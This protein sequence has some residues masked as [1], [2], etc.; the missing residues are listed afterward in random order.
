MFSSP[1]QRFGNHRLLVSN[2]G[3]ALVVSLI[4]II[5]IAIVLVGY[6]TTAGIERQTVQSHYAKIQAD[7]LNSMAVGVVASRLSTIPTTG[8]SWWIS[9]PG[10]I[11]SAPYTGT[12]TRFVELTSG[13]STAVIVDQS[14]DLNPASLTQGTGVLVSS[15][16][17]PF[18]VQW[19]YVHDDGT[20]STSA[21]GTSKIAGR[22]AFWTDDE[23]ARINVNTAISGTVALAEKDLDLGPLAETGTLSITELQKL[24]QARVQNQQ[25]FNSVDDIK[26]VSDASEIGSLVARNKESLTHYSQSPALNRF[27]EPKI[28]L[29]TQASLADSLPFFDILTNPNTDPGVEANLNKAKIEA[30]FAKLYAYFS[31][32]AS[33]WGLTYT[34]TNPSAPAASTYASKTLFQKYA[35]S[36]GAGR[37]VAQI[38][39]NLI[40]YVRSVESSQLAVLPLRGAFPSYLAPDTFTYRETVTPNGPNGSYQSNGILGNSRRPHVVEMGLW[41][42]DVPATVSGGTS[43]YSGTYKARILWPTNSG[44][45]I[46]IVNNCQMFATFYQV[47][48]EA[49]KFVMSGSTT[50]T[51]SGSSIDGADNPVAPGKYCTVTGRVNI[52]Q[53]GTLRPQHA[54]IRMAI[55]DA[56]TTL[57]YDLVP[58]F[59]SSAAAT[60]AS[61]TISGTGVPIE[62]MNSI[63]VDD[64]SLGQNRFNW[65]LNTG[66]NTFHTQIAP[67]QSTLGA[68][69]NTSF[70]PQQDADSSGKITDVSTYPP[71]FK[72]TSGNP[73]GLVQSVGELG[74]VH[75]GG[76]GTKLAGVPWRTVRFQPRKAPQATLPDWLLLD[77]FTVPYRENPDPTNASAMADKALL[78]SSTDTIGGRVNLNEKLWPFSGTTTRLAPLRTLLL[79]VKPT[80]SGTQ[81]DVLVNNIINQNLTP[82]S[83]SN[84]TSIGIA[85]GPKD[86]VAAGL[87][88]MP[89]EVSEV[90]GLADGEE[91]EGVVRGLVQYLTTNSNVFSVYS[92]GQKIQQR[93]NGTFRVLGESRWRTLLE[94][95]QES[96]VWKTRIISTTELG[97]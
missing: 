86:L 58:V 79:N 43:T 23:S 66:T 38:V 55:L 78:H 12:S 90:Q 35:D 72:G 39:L 84:N 11:A 24:K 44:T 18:P 32:P 54:S 36:S 15:A 25:R 29:T 28:V 96:G 71:P 2:R 33:A 45:S 76:M 77:L 67:L 73:I 6:V 20:Q 22:Y 49:D 68:A 41:L 51:I 97:L 69:V 31:K 91:N 65:V 81:A 27:G 64:P 74:L 87:Y 82:S 30:L 3:S 4:F 95:Y 42:P 89:G 83:A 26:S 48:A 75:T 46:N 21:S 13:S 8:T 1:E 50:F 80:L 37:N 93:Q 56:S 57:G 53:T 61:Y 10:R 40:D 52:V 63:S 70:L 5:L 88:L 59:A 19:I 34:G 7:L 94:R 47:P 85:F 9:S 14:A 17:T 62:R 16:T 92:V 60:D